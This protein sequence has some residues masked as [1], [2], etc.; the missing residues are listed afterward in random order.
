MKQKYQ[1]VKDMQSKQL[2]IK[3]YAVLAS[4]PRRKDVP[5]ILEEDYTLLS[6]QTYD[7]K[8]VKKA[9]SEGKNTLI[10]LLRSRNFF[11]VGWCID[12][13]SDSV[14]A[15]F[16]S[17]EEQSEDLVFDDKNFIAQHLV[18]RDMPVEI[19]EILETP[20]DIDELLTEDDSVEDGADKTIPA[21]A[22]PKQ[23]DEEKS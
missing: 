11:P 20:D 16:E 15:M 22:K 19:E 21:A 17:K 6:E 8:E 3:E 18:E 10:G 1:I 23:V 5:T 4:N 12:K 9:I 2:L 14:I 7:H 13:I